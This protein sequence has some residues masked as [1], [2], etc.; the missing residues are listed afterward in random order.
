MIQLSCNTHPAA[1]AWNFWK[2][3]HSVCGYRIP[4]RVQTT[5]AK[6]FEAE[7]CENVHQNWTWWWILEPLNQPLP[8]GPIRHSRIVEQPEAYSESYTETALLT[9]EKKSACQLA[10]CWAHY[11]KTSTDSSNWPLWRC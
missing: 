3:Q 4:L 9:R 5:H 1:L 10:R 7:N 2:T 11:V 8:P 6:A